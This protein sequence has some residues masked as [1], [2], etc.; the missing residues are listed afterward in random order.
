MAKRWTWKLE[1]TVLSF[2]EIRVYDLQVWNIFFGFV[3]EIWIL[4]IALQIFSKVIKN[5]R[6]LTISYTGVQGICPFQKSISYFIKEIPKRCSVQYSL[7][8]VLNYIFIMLKQIPYSM[9]PFP[10]PWIQIPCHW[11][12]SLVSVLGFCS[13]FGRSPKPQ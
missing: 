5:F 2:W 10:T 12:Q 7:S 4:E 3:S 1:S 9:P 8:M 11:F 6:V 13:R